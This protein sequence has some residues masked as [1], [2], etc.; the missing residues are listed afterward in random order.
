VIEKFLLFPPKPF[1][2]AIKGSIQLNPEETLSTAR[3]SG[4]FRAKE[5]F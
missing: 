4:N 2:D 3:K 5:A 1:H